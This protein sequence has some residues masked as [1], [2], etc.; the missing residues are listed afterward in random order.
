MNLGKKSRELAMVLANLWK[1]QYC[2]RREHC[3]H[4]TVHTPRVNN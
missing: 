1:L 3:S 4:I 2:S